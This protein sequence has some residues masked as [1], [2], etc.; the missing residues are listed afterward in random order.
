MKF[1]SY[2]DRIAAS[3]VCQLW[4]EAS[5]HP[6]F[7]DQERVVVRTCVLEAS[8]VFKMSRK[9]Y[10][11]L[12]FVDLDVC[13]GLLTELWNNVRS[14][15]KTL[16]LKNCI[17]C[18]KDFIHIL[19]SCFELG[20]LTIDNCQ[21]LFMSGQLLKTSQDI[22]MVE[23][24]LKNVCELN[25][26]NNRYLSDAL[27]H[28]LVCLMPK[29][30]SIS[31][32]SVQMSYHG[33][34]Y[35]KFYPDRLIF[36][37]PDFTSEALLTFQH[38]LS[39]VA[40]RA[41]HI[42]NINLSRTLVDS[43]A[44]TRIA[45]LEDLQLNEIHLVGCGQLNN[46][47]I[48]SLAQTQF[49]LNVLELS[50]SSRITDQ[51]LI[52]VCNHLFNLRKLAL[53]N[54][55]AITDLGIVNLKNLHYLKELDLSQC[56]QIS[57]DGIANGLCSKIN[58]RLRKLYLHHLSKLTSEVIILLVKFLPNLIYLNLNFCYNAVRDDSI[59]SIFQHQI[60]LRSLKIAGCSVTDAGL[61]GMCYEPVSSPTQ[62]VGVGLLQF[63]AQCQQEEVEDLC[64][65]SVNPC[66]TSVSK[67]TYS[68]ARL[69]G[70]VNLL[71]LFD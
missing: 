7:C 6:T 16:Y 52:Q 8:N 38:F 2:S 35:K 49:S 56:E 36:E 11:H 45:Y 46:N 40:N 30:S 53:R 5:L 66:A 71:Y 23:G 59:Q 64:K 47:G 68:L 55:R 9:P 50:N 17:V 1:L 70:Q 43:N 42:K 37:N 27:F 63:P 48:F 13:H 4:Y 44:L 24:A 22:K 60:Y 57:N 26:S 29:L 19:S 51:A 62:L 67:E 25:L 33:G 28:R 21:E 69:K 31:L 14:N 39:F 18:Y 34:L 61:T 32:E 10:R 54:C 3:Q 41:K 65:E 12:T 20:S 58:T 15:L